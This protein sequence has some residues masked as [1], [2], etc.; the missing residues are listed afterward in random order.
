MRPRTIIYVVILA[1]IAVGV[2]IGLTGRSPLDLNVLPDRNPLFVKLAD[3]S[4]RNGYTVKVLNRVRE[5][6]TYLLTVGGLED[7]KL[8]VLGQEVEDG[9]PVLL[10]GE[11]DQVSTYR[12]FVTAPSSTVDQSVNDLE[13]V[14]TDQATGEVFGFDTVFR[15]PK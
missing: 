9:Q 3:G 8:G 11:P 5:P 6:K 13:V 14:L 7:V 10:D 15:G 12:L 2:L 4:I 1:I